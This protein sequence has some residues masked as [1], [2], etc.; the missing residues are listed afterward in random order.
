MFSSSYM[1]IEFWNSIRKTQYNYQYSPFLQDL[2]FAS[3]LPSNYI[4]SVGVQLMC[5]L[6]TV[7]VLL[8]KLLS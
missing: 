1:N 4:G 8:C 5:L 2:S 6:N 7:H 3:L